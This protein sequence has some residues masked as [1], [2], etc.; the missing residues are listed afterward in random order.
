MHKPL[1]CAALCLAFAASAAAEDAA[2]ELEMFSSPDVETQAAAAPGQAEEKKTLGF[3]G[4]IISVVEDIAYST[5]SANSLNSYLVGNFMLDAR[6]KNGIK[7]FANME[8]SYQSATRETSS[9]L[10]E[11]FL[12]FNLNRRVYF[13]TGKQVLQWGRCYLWNPVDLVNVEKKPFVRK[14]GYRDGAYGMKFHV[15]FGTDYNI[16]GFLDTGGAAEDRDLGGALKFELLA[17]RTEMAF[18]G[19]A[20]RDRSPVFGYDISSRLGGVDVAGEV[21]VSGRDNSRFIRNSGGVLETYRKKEEWVTKAAV[22][23]SEGFRLGNFNDRLT[24]TAEFFYNQTGYTRSP[25]RDRAV[26]GF[27]GPLALLL[28]AGS[29]TEFLLGNGLYEPNYLARYYGAVF[30]SVSRFIITDMTL[31]MNYIRN[32]N[33]DSGVLSAGVTCKN[34]SDFS[35][36]LL[37]T[38]FLGPARGEYTVSGARLGAQLTF[39]VSF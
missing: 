7:A 35:A 28:P 6:L 4:E 18:S 32:L 2:A 33:D 36:G 8:T 34:I 10:R 19:W 13:R 20:K 14:I 27:S 16:Y 17:G 5:A 23:F 39:G 9:V 29:K 30:A 38:S 24:L 22:N 26:Y 21:S 37:V 3:S 15:P 11:A 12:D 1:I 31:N 25:F